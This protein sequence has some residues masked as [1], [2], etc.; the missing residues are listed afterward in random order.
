[1]ACNYGYQLC[2]PSVPLRPLDKPANNEP[3]PVLCRADIKQKSARG[4][5]QPKDMRSIF[6]NNP[7]PDARH[8]Q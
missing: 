6:F 2:N 7:G 4:R 5:N 8:S 1:M 3:D